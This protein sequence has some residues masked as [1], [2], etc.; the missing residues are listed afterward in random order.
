MRPISFMV[1]MTIIIAIFLSMIP[2]NIGAGDPTKKGLETPL[3]LAGFEVHKGPMDPGR[4]I[5]SQDKAYSGPIVDT[6]AHIHYK[7]KFSSESK[8]P[9]EILATAKKNGVEHQ[10]FLPTPNEGRFRNLDTNLNLRR[11]I[12]K[13]GGKRVGLLCGSEYLTVWME[14]IFHRGYTE[15]D[16]DRHLARLE[17]DI[18]NGQCVGVGEIGPYHFEKKRGQNVIKFPLNFTPFLKMVGII[19]EKKVWL[20][21]HVEPMTPKG[22]SYEDEVFGGIALLYRLYPELR[23]ILSH[24]AMTNS[25]NARAL[26]ETYP[27]LMMNLK[28]VL[29]G[30]SLAWDNLGPI[31]NGKGELFED[32]ATLFEAMPERFM[33][34]TDYRWGEKPSKKY[35]KRIRGMRRIL[36]S[37]DSSVAS[38]IALKNA[39][40]VFGN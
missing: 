15:E 2:E 34:G 23:L 35:R 12:L 33:I 4:P 10:I 31:T 38:T 26:L 7:R 24:S 1:V 27:N 36:G 32:W 20:D 17:Q 13:I 21:L 3:P 18:E 5:R 29:T 6:H 11:Q 16:L 14:G 30:K 37:L 39:Q 8:L 25:K 19:A 22:R 9:E 40:R 28:A